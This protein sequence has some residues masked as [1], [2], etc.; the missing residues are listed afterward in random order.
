MSDD[1][2]ITEAQIP[3]SESAPYFSNIPSK[4][5]T[6]A[7]P[8]K[9]LSSIKGKSSE[10]ILKKPKIGESHLLINGSIPED[11]NIDTE[12]IKAHIVGKTANELFIPF[13]APLKKLSK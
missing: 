12:T 2:I 5:A 13:F 6:D 8:E 3:T 1:A 7:L 11:K 4:V 10:G 9:G